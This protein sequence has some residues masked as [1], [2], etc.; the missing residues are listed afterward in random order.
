LV[1]WGSACFD[2]QLIDSKGLELNS[3]A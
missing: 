1:V 2:E 3:H